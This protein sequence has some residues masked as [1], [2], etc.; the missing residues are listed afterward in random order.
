[1]Q[2][3]GASATTTINRKDFGIS[4]GGLMDNGGAM[5]GDTVAITLEVEATKEA[6]K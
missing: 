3:V 5:I 1:V 4:Y 2:H 6:A